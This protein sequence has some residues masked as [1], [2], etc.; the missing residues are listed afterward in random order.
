MLEF[1]DYE[2]IVG[3]DFNAVWDPAVDRSAASETPDQRQASA[4]LRAWA[5]DTGF[6]DMWRM[7]NPSLK[8]FSFFSSRHKTFSRIDYLFASPHLFDSFDVS[9][10]SIALSDH[11]AIFLTASLS[12]LSSCA[13][14]W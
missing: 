4:A 7:V 11:K 13:P 14:R 10:L 12:K 3:A 2:F 5:R 8:D 6:V 1:T 9:L